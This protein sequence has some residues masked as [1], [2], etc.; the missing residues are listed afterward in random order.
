MTGTFK[1]TLKIIEKLYRNDTKIQLEKHL[2]IS[3]TIVETHTHMHLHGTTT[4]D[5][6]ALS[7]TLCKLQT[8]TFRTT[9]MLTEPPKQF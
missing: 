7:P 5:G 4:Y 9:L 2:E 8:R 1:K 3:L 6:F